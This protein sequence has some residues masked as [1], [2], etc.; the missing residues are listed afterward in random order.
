MLC[1]TQLRSPDLTLKIPEMVKG[2]QVTPESFHM[3][4]GLNGRTAFTTTSRHGKTGVVCTY[5]MS[6]ETLHQV[7]KKQGCAEYPSRKSCRK[8]VHKK[9]K[10]SY[11]YTLGTDPWV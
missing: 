4:N 11:L 1:L 7:Q 8:H 9:L 5:H 6:S 3:K 2:G 10:E